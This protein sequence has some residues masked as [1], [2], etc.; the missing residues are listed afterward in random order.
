MEIERLGKIP[1]ME[2]LAAI[3]VGHFAEY[4]YQNLDS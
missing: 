1:F 2:M 3:K 4:I